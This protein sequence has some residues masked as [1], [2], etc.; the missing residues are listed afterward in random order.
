MRENPLNV[1][2]FCNFCLDGMGNWSPIQSLVQN[3][4]VCAILQEN[5]AYDVLYFLN[6]KRRFE[7]LLGYEERRGFH[8]NAGSLTIKL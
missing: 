4:I 5:Y 3:V 8:S 1:V 2:L 7:K 6:L